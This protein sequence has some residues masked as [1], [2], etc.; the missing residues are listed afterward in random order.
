M[1][2]SYQVL[3][4]H[5]Q[6]KRIISGIK[7]TLKKY[8]R[9]LNPTWTAA[10]LQMLAK[11]AAV[12]SGIESWA[13]RAFFVFYIKINGHGKAHCCFCFSCGIPGGSGLAAP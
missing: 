8:I 10:T 4:L 12:V 3:L 1:F 11:V 9:H 6:I 13:C 7:E 2:S 5:E